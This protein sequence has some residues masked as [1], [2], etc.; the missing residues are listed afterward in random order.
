MWVD[1][2]VE[3]VGWC[4]VVW[5]GGVGWVFVDWLECVVVD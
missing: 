3:R 2:V 4:G 1:W 5:L